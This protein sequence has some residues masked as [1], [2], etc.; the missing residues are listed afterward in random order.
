MLIAAALMGCTSSSLLVSAPSFHGKYNLGK[1]LGQGGFGQVRVAHPRNKQRAKEEQLADVCAVKIIPVTK[2]AKG[3]RRLPKTDSLLKSR[4]VKEASVW[5]LAS[6]SKHIVQLHEVFHDTCFCYMVMERCR[7]S[8]LDDM[9]RVT[10]SS[11][12]GIARVFREMLVSIAHLHDKGLVHRDV[13]LNNF[14]FGGDDGNSVKLCD[15]GLTTSLVEG[16]LLTGV[17]GTAPYKAPEML[18]ECGYSQSVDVWSL[19]VAAYLLLFGEFPYFPSLG[20]D[21]EEV[22]FRGT[23]APAFRREDDCQAASEQAVSFVRAL[24]ERSVGDRCTAGEAL[25][26][27]FV[28]EQLEDDDFATSK[29]MSTLKLTIG[30]ARQRTLELNTLITDPTEQ[31]NVD[32]VLARLQGLHSPDNR[33]NYARKNAR[34]FSFDGTGPSTKKNY[35][36]DSEITALP[37]CCHRLHK[38][39]THDGSLTLSPSLFNAWHDADEESKSTDA[40]DMD[41]ELDEFEEDIAS[42]HT[43]DSE[44]STWMDMPHVI[45]S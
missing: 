36:F 38:G 10:K 31:R 24:L 33:N 7:C 29:E 42:P 17:C 37:D 45:A 15:F 30:K 25:K 6:G 16:K 23:P 22:I 21:F 44:M 1:K 39:S 8:V 40:E 27:P 12:V 32:D 18:Q 14:L 5:T 13:K 9:E 3:R 28:L 43:P 34:H 19:G 11:E 35:L 26:L 41:E 20:E 2:K 4:A